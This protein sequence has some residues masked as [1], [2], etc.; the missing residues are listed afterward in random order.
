MSEVPLFRSVSI[1]ATDEQ[2]IAVGHARES[3]IG[4]VQATASAEFEQ[5]MLD[6]RLVP[7]RRL[8]CCTFPTPIE[9]SP[10][11]ESQNARRIAN[12]KLKG[13]RPG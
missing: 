13:T 12:A 3:A 5:S 1:K 6:T 7:G 11:P 2:D 10:P 8:G 4:D 9:K